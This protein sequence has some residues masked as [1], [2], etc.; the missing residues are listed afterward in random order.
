MAK[1]NGQ[2]LQ[3]Q[4]DDSGAV[5]RDVSKDVNSVDIPD[6]Y[7]ELDATGFTD[8][9]VRSIA[10]MPSFPVEIAGD[11]DATALSLYQ[12]LKGIVGQSA[13]SKTL[14]IDVGQGA[15][16]TTGDPRFTGE[17]WCS[18]LNIAATPQGK[19]TIAASMRP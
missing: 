2:Y 18:K 7:G 4:I 5:L 9:A 12:V 13:V 6:E 3:V 16:P 1:L 17:F 14:T 19:L 8:G 11:F 10:G 15:L